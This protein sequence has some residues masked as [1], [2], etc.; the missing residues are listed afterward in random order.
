MWD[1]K[2]PVTQRA[3]TKNINFK[4]L[5]ESTISQARSVSLDECIRSNFRKGPARRATTGNE[6]HLDHRAASVAAARMWTAWRSIR[7]VAWR[8]AD[9]R[10]SAT[11]ANWTLRD[12]HRYR[13]TCPGASNQERSRDP[14]G[15]NGRRM[16][17]NRRQ[18]P[19]NGRRSRSHP[20]WPRIDPSGSSPRSSLDLTMPS[21]VTAPTWPPLRASPNSEG[22]LTAATRELSPRGWP[23][24]FSTSESE[25][26]RDR[27]CNWDRRDWTR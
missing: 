14:R 4:I 16:S 2:F 26:C 9:I 15:T 20:R 27:D 6:D 12:G 11:P 18:V 1:S 10:R 22:T 3:I 23:S 7:S 21:G 8:T 5:F 24:T 19:R 17:M 13:R 25:K